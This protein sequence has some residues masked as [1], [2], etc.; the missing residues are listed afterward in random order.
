M[1]QA[2]GSRRNRTALRN[3]TPVR[4]NPF[5][6][7]FFPHPT[8]YILAY[9]IDDGHGGKVHVNVGFSHFNQLQF[10]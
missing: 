9:T 8:G 1:Q 10:H 3:N 5:V 6:D 2:R 7:I 4:Y